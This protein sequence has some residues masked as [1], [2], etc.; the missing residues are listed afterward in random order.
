MTAMRWMA[1]RGFLKIFTALLLIVAIMFVSNYMVYKR[2]I[3]GIY[4]Q[5]SENN[6][7]VVR[8]IVRIF[9][10]SFVNIRDM[11]ETIQKL[12]YSTW[13]A[14][15]AN[16]GADDMAE[17][18]LMKRSLGEIVPRIDYIEE[19]V[20]F[21]NYS[22]LAVTT[23]GTIHLK[24]LFRLNFSN[25]LYN[26]EFWTTYGNSMHASKVFPAGWYSQWSSDS[27]AV[28]QNPRKLLV[29]SSGNQLYN[30]NVLVFL[31]VSKLLEHVNQ[32][33]MMQGTSL[34]ILDKERNV[35]LGTEE[36]LNLVDVLSELS[37]KPGQE[38]TVK[39]TGYEYTIYETD[40]FTYIN[41]VPYRFADLNPVTKANQRIIM[42]AIA[43]AV[44]LSGVLSLYL[45]K[46]IRIL[47]K[48]MGGRDP[49]EIDF[50]AI[51]AGIVRL[52]EENE[53][54]QARL[55]EADADLARN[56]FVG[57]LTNSALSREGEQRLRR[58]IAEQVQQ[59]YFVMAAFQLKTGGSGELEQ[60]IE[61]GRTLAAI[62][63][64]LLATDSS[65]AAF[66]AGEN[67][68]LAAIGVGSPAEREQTLKR[69]R[70]FVKLAE[71][72]VWS[73]FAVLAAVSRTYPA[74]IEHLGKSYRDVTE[75]F[76]RRNIG[77]KETVIDVPAI[78]P[79]WRV[80]FPLD[81]A[82]KLPR[83]LAGGN[84][85]EC[86]RLIDDIFA[87]NAERG[88]H[89]HQLLSVAKTMFYDMLQLL[90]AGEPKG[91]LALEAAFARRTED[92][93]GHEDIREA[94]L[95]A[96]RAIADNVRRE[97][98]SKLDAA[99]VARYIDL[100]YMDHLHL[101]HMA[102]QMETSAKYFSNYFKKTFGVNF[103][104][105]VNK[106]RLSHAKELL[107]NPELSVAEI[108]EKIGYLNS[109]TF[110]T[111]FKKYV[112]LSPSEFRRNLSGG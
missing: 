24:E 76:A 59:P 90:E 58:M 107:K 77:A 25:P 95:Q 26:Y 108:G 31:D 47:F 8:N 80:Y 5:V 102:E 18:Y 105:Y 10:E 51:G 21:N 97:V 54:F 36:S 96:M 67:L 70:C 65:A 98:R 82:E 38:S 23:A 9:E 19:V 43:F 84:L 15:G 62:R 45:Y 4:D 99:S 22:D 104:D 81:E 57:A 92:A 89:Y 73:G 41:K 3:S 71:K 61:P 78:R 33:A 60:P 109:T 13:N 28:N 66:Q 16:S 111:T 85:H 93:F 40:Y 63:S 12:P 48:L 2:S 100:H 74:K 101:D 103:V 6:R 44:L 50:R 87:H 72:D 83:Y 91:N 64:G 88:I 69:L 49:R 32:K 56:A 30:P 20:V 75:G 7:L 110:T 46:P 1:N 35:I 27:G 55:D 53:A 94:L 29:V 34:V 14:S 106:V 52:K 42:I 68:F 39:K 11:T 79:V 112:G 37:D 17:I 86:E